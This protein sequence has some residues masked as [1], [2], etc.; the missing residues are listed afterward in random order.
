MVV[1]VCVYVDSSRRAEEGH[2][3]KWQRRSFFQTLK[4]GFSCVVDAFVFCHV[5]GTDFVL[6]HLVPPC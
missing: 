6:L 4:E 1:H 2:A 5:V 3:S